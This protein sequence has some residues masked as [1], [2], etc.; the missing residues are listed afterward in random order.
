MNVPLVRIGTKIV[1][2]VGT[3]YIARGYGVFANSPWRFHRSVQSISRT[4]DDEFDHAMRDQTRDQFPVSRNIPPTALLSRFLSVPSGPHPSSLQP[5]PSTGLPVAKRLIRAAFLLSRGV[6]IRLALTLLLEIFI[7]PFAI[8][9]SPAFQG[10]ETRVGVVNISEGIKVLMAG[11]HY[12][13]CILRQNK[14]NI[15][16]A[17]SASARYGVLSTQTNWDSGRDDCSDLR[18]KDLVA[19]GREPIVGSLHGVSP[20]EN[21]CVNTDFFSWRLPDIDYGKT[22]SKGPTLNWSVGNS[23]RNNVRSLVPLKLASEFGQG[24]LVN[25]GKLNGGLSLFAEFKYELLRLLSAAPHLVQLFAHDQALVTNDSCAE[26]RGNGDSSGEDQH[27]PFL[28]P[29]VRGFYVGVHILTAFVLCVGALWNIWRRW[30]L[31]SVIAGLAI[32]SV[33]AV[34]IFHAAWEMLCV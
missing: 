11:N 22:N 6:R 30:N 9:D 29:G 27:Q 4:P 8:G 25:S 33:V 1:P 26:Q 12:D 23:V 13:S 17:H 21:C 32:Y 19:R 5:L 10:P 15:F 28:T 18:V 7:V 16:F 31:L 14:V 2:Q 3:S 24:G 34:I 20:K